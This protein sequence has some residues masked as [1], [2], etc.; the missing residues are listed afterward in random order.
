MRL[1][2]VSPKN[3]R[4]GKQELK[5]YC[6]IASNCKV[7]VIVFPSTFLPYY[8]NSG[9]FYKQADILALPQ[10]LPFGSDLL[11][12]VGVNEQAT[13][14]KRYK[15]VVTFNAHC[16]L[17][18]HRKKNLEE[19]YL[20]KGFSVGHGGDN[21]VWTDRLTI[22]TLECFELLFEENWESCGLV[23]GSVGFGMKAT[24]QNYACNYFEQWLDIVRMYCLKYNCPALIACNGQHED[25]MTVAID[26]NGKTVGMAR[27][28]GFFI[29]D[30]NIHNAVEIELNPFH[31]GDPK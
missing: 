20:Q 5:E 4:S 18:V 6:V 23:T 21:I 28:H 8:R 25:F 31:Q 30:M 7:D 12:I 24:T 14:G 11:V 19:H 17:N 9:A 13:D 2:A 29:I 27:R 26:N 22:N 3:T 15:S 16:V 10:S 1:M